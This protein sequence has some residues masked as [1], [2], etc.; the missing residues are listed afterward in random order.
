MPLPAWS[1]TSPNYSTS[2]SLAPKLTTSLWPGSTLTP[3]LNHFEMH[4]SIDNLNISTQAISISTSRSCTASAPTV[5]DWR[6]SMCGEQRRHKE[7][8]LSSQKGGKAQN[9][10]Q[11]LQT[12]QVSSQRSPSTG[13]ASCPALAHLNILDTE[14][15]VT[16]S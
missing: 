4:S 12:S 8:L 5:Q 16:E 15:A 9:V 11:S 10:C 7:V 3:G 1:L 6:H 13:K 2:T 14:V